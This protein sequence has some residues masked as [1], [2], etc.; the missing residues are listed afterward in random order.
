MDTTA[1][2]PGQ[3]VA[4]FYTIV[5][6]L[7]HGGMGIV[8]LARE[9]QAGRLVAIKSPLGEF[10]GDT[11]A[12]RRFSREATAWMELRSHP[13]V[14]RPFD[15]CEVGYLPRIFME[16][17]DAGSL[18]GLLARRPRGL[19]FQQV[20]DLAA[21]ICWAMAFAHEQGMV[22][23]D[24][25]PD[26]ILLQSE[27]TGEFQAKVTDFGLVRLVSQANP[28][29]VAAAL[30]QVHVPGP[31][32][33][34][35][36]LSAG[37]IAGTPNYMAP[38]QWTGEGIGPAA[39]IYAM[40]LILFELFTGRR[41]FDLATHPYCREMDI[42]PVA[43]VYFYRLLHC[44]YEPL[45]PMGLRP[46]LPPAVGELLRR[47]LAKQVADRP[48]S[49][50]EVADRL[51][52]GLQAVGVDA[53]RRPEPDRLAINAQGKREHAWALV[54]LGLGTLGR[55]D[56][57][58]A[59]PSCRKAFALFEEI[60]DRDGISA[61]YL[62]LGLVHVERGEYEQAV[63]MYQQALAIKQEIGDRAGI[64]ACYLSLGVVHADRGE[65]EQAVGMYQQALAIKQEIGDR[66]GISACYLSLGV[67]H[68]DRGEYEQAVAMC[69]QA[70]AINQEIGDRA[71]M[72]T[73]YGNLGEIH[74]RRGELEQGVAMYQ[75]ALAIN[76][77]I[78]DRAGI[79][80]CYLNLGLA[81]EQR[82]RPGEALKMYQASLRLKRE[83]GLPIP[84]GLEPTIRRLGG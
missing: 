5:K 2:R 83:L 59:E 46:D 17:C 69:Q 78:G 64:S 16:Y 19:P 67:V 9:G 1:W 38:E 58:D 74:R 81:E 44:E 15:V 11:L 34:P 43:R 63:A 32:G 10:V 47:C 12:R 33:G 68:A 21:Q 70:L 53:G 82:R 75:Q 41:A 25:K 28:A 23:R 26:N 35:V 14:V 13:N 80:D 37:Q 36:E 7:G 18:A 8:H 77:E 39:D 52:R 27:A 48:A 60:G 4:D 54:R 57:Y 3:V 55:G 76:Q 72:S 79:S 40:G 49:A 51:A 65:Y 42:A 24:L 30:S 20:Y 61:C 22:H 31:A 50:L 84:K 29:E 66:A 6:E 71:G 56:L 62:N 45:D 73:C